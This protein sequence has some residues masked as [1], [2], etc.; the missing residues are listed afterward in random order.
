MNYQFVVKKKKAHDYEIDTIEAGSLKEAKRLF[1][2]RHPE[3]VKN[4]TII[5]SENGFEEL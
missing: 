3:D 5:S 1:A 2:E 4:I